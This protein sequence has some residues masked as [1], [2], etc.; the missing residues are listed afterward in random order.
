MN[1]T[2]SV[3]IINETDDDG[4]SNAL[5]LVTVSILFVT[6]LIRFRFPFLCFEERKS[7][8]NKQQGAQIF[9]PSLKRILNDIVLKMVVEEGIFLFLNMSIISTGIGRSAS[10]F[11]GR[12]TITRMLMVPTRIEI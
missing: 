12:L 7:V 5:A 2:E 8:P 10:T 3:S 6:I 4:S 9:F 1:S 11:I